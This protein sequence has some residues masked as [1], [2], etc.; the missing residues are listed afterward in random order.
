MFW[1]CHPQP[2]HD[3]FHDTPQPKSVSSTVEKL[4]MYCANPQLEKLTFILWGIFEIIFMSWFLWQGQNVCWLIWEIITSN[5]ESCAHVSRTHLFKLSVLSL[6]SNAH[7]PRPAVVGCGDYH[8]RLKNTKEAEGVWLWPKPDR[9]YYFSPW[10]LPAPDS[11]RG[12][13]WPVSSDPEEE[14]E[15]WT[16]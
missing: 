12:T 13:R 4:I 14:W 9:C 8:W 2:L 7:S 6:S 5:L 10:P 3:N 15:C 16:L 11:T 1:P